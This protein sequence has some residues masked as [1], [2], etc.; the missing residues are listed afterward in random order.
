MNNKKKQRSSG[1]GLPFSK[2]SKN[3]RL[4]DPHGSPESSVLMQSQHS[5]ESEDSSGSSQS[6]LLMQSQHSRESED[7]SESAA[8]VELGG[9]EPQPTASSCSVEDTRAASDLPGSPEELVSQPPSQNSVRRFVPQFAKSKKTIT[10]KAKAWKEVPKSCTGSQET[11]PELGA[12]QAGSQPNK[13]SLKFPFHDARRP[14]DQTWADGT[15]S[16]ERTISP[17]IGSLGN[18]DFEMQRTRVQDSDSQERYLSDGDAEGR[19]ADSRTPQEGGAQEGGTG[20]QQTGEPQEGESTLYISAS[21]PA[22]DPTVPVPTHIISSTGAIPSCSSPVD[23][24]LTDSVIIDVSLDPSL[25][26]QRAPEV[27]TLPG[28]PDGQTPGGGCSGTLLG[29]TPLAEETTAGREEARLEEGPHGDILAS[30][31]EA[32]VPGKQKPMVDAG[33][34][35][36]I[37]QEMSSAVKTKHSGSDGQ[38][39]EEIGTLT[40]EAQPMNQKVVELSSLNCHQDFESLSLSPDTSSQLK[41]SHAGSD[42]PQRTKA[43]HSSPGIPTD[44][45]EQQPAPSTGDEA[46]W[47]ESST[48]ELDF[49]PDSQIQGALDA[50]NVEALSEQGFPAGNVPGHGWPVPN[51]CAIRGSPTAMAKAQPRPAVGTWAQEACRMQ[52][53]TDTVRGLVVELSSLNRLIMSTYRDLEA[54]KRRKTKPLPHLTKGAGS[55]ARGDHGW[56]EL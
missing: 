50:P 13:E 25:L 27:V 49:L 47:Q 7:T 2:P 44:L 46:T 38:L 22:S 33:D 24:S 55:L 18:S 1:S 52:D 35:G 43:C 5:G 51:P 12:F 17:D 34:P 6:S 41:H 19:Q 10:R 36:Y 23:A 21:A 53:A 16:K 54:F 56:R 20:T 31:T 8:S 29:H 26:Q 40:L 14:E 39:P 30:L 3:P 15:C 28:S 9:E 45:A 48:M 37:E 32:A 42:L 11:W 4:K